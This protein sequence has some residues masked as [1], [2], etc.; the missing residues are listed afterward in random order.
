MLD[1]PFEYIELNRETN[2]E[3]GIRHYVTPEGE[4]L[5]S[6]TTILAQT[7]DPDDTG[8]LQAWIDWVGEDKA[9]KIRDQAGARGTLMHQRLEWYVKDI[10][11]RVGSNMI[12]QQANN[13]ANLIIEKGLVHMD[14]YWGSEMSLWYPGLYAGTTDLVGVWKGKPAIVDF[15]QA[16]KPK[17]PEVVLNYKT[18]LCGYALAHNE[19]YGTDIKTGV[20]LI[21]TGDLLY[22]EFVV[23]DDEFEEFSDKWFDRVEAYYDK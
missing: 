8:A 7:A 11:K 19:V 16:N 5:P 12:H 21:A 1:S 10:E 13:M 4:F 3:T 18:Q 22:Q 14:E 17:T 20:I 6:V 15:K 2:E 23:E 9:I